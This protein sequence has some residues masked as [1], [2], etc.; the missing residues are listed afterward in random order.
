M[1]HECEAQPMPRLTTPNYLSRHYQLKVLWAE[2]QNRFTLLSWNDQINLHRYYLLTLDKTELELVAHRRNHIGDPSLPQRAGRAYA[3]LM[4]GEADAGAG[5]V[6]PDGRVLTVRVLARPE[7]D[8]RLLARTFLEMAKRELRER[9]D[10]DT[11]A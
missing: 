5:T 3:R 6:I 8:I 10:Q 7:P 4:R 9:Q 1:S 11:A 2:D